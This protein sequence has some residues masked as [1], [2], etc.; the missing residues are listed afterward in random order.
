M[1]GLSERHFDG[2]H[3]TQW[4]SRRS[5]QTPQIRQW[6]ALG[7]RGTLQVMHQFLLPFSSG[8][9]SSCS[10][11]PVRLAAACLVPSMPVSL[12]ARELSHLAVHCTGF[13]L[14]STTPGSCLVCTSA[15][16]VSMTPA[17][18]TDTCT[19]LIF[20]PGKTSVMNK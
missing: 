8:S 18:T 11:V 16:R 2:T 10:E 14:S 20:P 17:V 12:S 7:G 5:T 3:Q 19:R 9:M 4:W 6:P 13:W 15:T 1:Q